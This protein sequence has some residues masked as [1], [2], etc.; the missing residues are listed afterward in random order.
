MIINR[1]VVGKYEIAQ[2][3]DNSLVILGSIDTPKD[4]RDIVYNNFVKGYKARNRSYKL[5]LEMMDPPEDY[6][7][8]YVEATDSSEFGAIKTR[9]MYFRAFPNLS[10]A[11]VYMK[12][13]MHIKPLLDKWNNPIIVGVW[14]KYKGNMI[15]IKGKCNDYKEIIDDIT[16]IRDVTAS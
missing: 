15:K 2:A 16:L 1:K 12:L 4:I 3:S 14:I 8:S 7:L 11:D 10:S 13:G 9:S 6:E 5:Y